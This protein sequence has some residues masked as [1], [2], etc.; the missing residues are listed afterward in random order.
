MSA[1]GLTEYQSEEMWEE[2]GKDFS[3]MKDLPIIRQRCIAM[4]SDDSQTQLSHKLRGAIKAV[5]QDVQNPEW[6]QMVHHELEDN[7]LEKDI[8]LGPMQYVAISMT[9]AGCTQKEVAQV[10]GRSISTIGRWMK[11]GSKPRDLLMRAQ[12]EMFLTTFQLL[13]N[14]T[15]NACTRLNTL[16]DS[17]N[18]DIALR[19]LMFSIEKA[20]APRPFDPD[21]DTAW[22]GKQLLP[23]QYVM[24]SSDYYDKHLCPDVSNWK[25]QRTFEAIFT[26]AAANFRIERPDNDRPRSY[27]A[28]NKEIELLKLFLIQQ[29]I[30]FTE[31]DDRITIYSSFLSGVLMEINTKASAA[32][33]YINNRFCTGERGCSAFEAYRESISEEYLYYEGN[34]LLQI[35]HN[36]SINELIRLLEAMLYEKNSDSNQEKQREI[37]GATL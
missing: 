15:L 18:E 17:D 7:F 33:S 25:Q 23:Y 24:D 3:T 16:I 26:N 4:L 8:A 5:L 6:I 29:D 36:A 19:A 12:T 11:P 21:I 20:R 28:D 2:L 1:K 35:P 34:N 37:E 22:V 10:T 30:S 27:E 9:L 14:A 32:Y 13:R 31:Y